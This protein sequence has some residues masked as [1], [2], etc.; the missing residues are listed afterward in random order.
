MAISDWLIIIKFYCMPRL[1]TQPNQPMLLTTFNSIQL[2]FNSF[3]CFTITQK[4]IFIQSLKKEGRKEDE[5]DKEKI[6][7]Y[8]S[9]SSSSSATM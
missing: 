4:L 9:S 5:K 6:F 8:S 3:N 1:G 7:T 2:Q